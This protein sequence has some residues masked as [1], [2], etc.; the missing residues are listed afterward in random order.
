VERVLFFE[1][2]DEFE[3]G[4]IALEGEVPGMDLRDHGIS[5]NPVG[6]VQGVGVLEL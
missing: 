5:G 2:E 4:Q 6:V 1:I 3:V